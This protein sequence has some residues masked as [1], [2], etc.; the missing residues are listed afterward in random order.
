MT[1]TRETDPDAIADDTGGS[2]SADGPPSWLTDGPAETR[3]TTTRS[4]RLSPSECD[5]IDRA[6]AEVGMTTSAYLR[7]RVLGPGP[8][9]AAWRRAYELVREL[10]AEAERGPVSAER[11][12]RLRAAFEEVALTVFPEGGAGG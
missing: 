12:G 2:D 11:V 3:R 4:F 9:V 8:D 5:R 6:A 7:S 10:E 1:A